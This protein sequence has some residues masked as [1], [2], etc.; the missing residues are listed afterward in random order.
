[1]RP[2][3]FQG[4]ERL[5]AIW[6]AQSGQSYRIGASMPEF[7]DYKDQSHSFEYMANVLSGW[8]Y[9][10]T[11]QGEPRNVGAAGLGKCMPGVFAPSATLVF[12]DRPNDPLNVPTVQACWLSSAFFRAIGPP[13][14][15]GAVLHR[16]R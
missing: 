3:P 4:S 13:L 10:W 9:T 12:S 2:L 11:G 16:A 7:Q 8:T 14:V 15:N 6:A 1:L 5:F